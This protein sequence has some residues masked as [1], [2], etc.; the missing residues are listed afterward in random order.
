MELM[1]N[2]TRDERGVI[3]E[4]KENLT[5]MRSHECNLLYGTDVYSE[6]ERA[7]GKYLYVP[8][9]VPI[10][11]PN[12]LDKF[13]EY[14]FK[15]AIS[16]AK[17]V[18][19]TLSPKVAAS[20]QPYVA[21]DSVSPGWDLSVFAKNHFAPIYT[22]FPEIF[23][24]IHSHLPFV[25]ERDFRWSM[26]SSGLNV[27]LHR[28]YTS[29]IDFPSAVRIKLFDNNPF[30]TLSVEVHPTTKKSDRKFF[31]PIP[32]DTNTFAWNNLRTKHKS[33]FLT[34][35]GLRKILFLWRDELKTPLQ[36]NQYIDVIEKS[37]TAYVEETM[38]DTNDV[39]D[40][41]AI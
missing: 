22:D 13:V 7:Y 35:K 19:D 15:H 17:V 40:Y 38:I 30:E 21:I 14:F 6:L 1:T 3:H 28:D 23:D 11:V 20:D 41:I 29:M 8:L 37:I 32:K 9:A 5:K 31:L 24:Q 4:S 36:I 34:G 26:W 16:I 12:D 27:P 2:L 10:I 39:S 25:G 33:G 18:E